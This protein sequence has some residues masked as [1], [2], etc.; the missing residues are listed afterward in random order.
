[1]PRICPEKKLFRLWFGSQH[2]KAFWEASVNNY[3]NIL[4]KQT[5]NFHAVIASPSTIFKK[6]KK[7]L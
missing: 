4:D 7:W 3:R 2:A 1:M 5:T 6:Y